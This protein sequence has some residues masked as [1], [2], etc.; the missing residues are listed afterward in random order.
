MRMLFVLSLA[1]GTLFIAPDSHQLRIRYGTP[2][3][4]RFDAGED[5]GL[6]VEYGSEG[7][8]C[9]IV[10]E[11][12]QVLLH[13]QEEPKYMRPERVGQLIDELV[14]PS[15]RGRIVNTLMESMGCS[16][17]RVEQY[18]NVWISRNSNMCLPLKIERESS[19]NV[20]FKRGEC[21]AS[22]YVQFQK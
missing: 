6:T 10:L 11:R 13:G 16:E 5:I 17:G 14:P 15:S 2:E 12:R 7:L 1:A 8:A 20:A 9:Q 21:P 19:A 18:E 4:E 22:R 3:V